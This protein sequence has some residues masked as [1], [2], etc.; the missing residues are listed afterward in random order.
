M[1]NKNVTDT[2]VRA[3]GYNVETKRWQNFGILLGRP[4]QLCFPLFGAD[5]FKLLRAFVT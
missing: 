3:L 1:V 4:N 2:M 5:F